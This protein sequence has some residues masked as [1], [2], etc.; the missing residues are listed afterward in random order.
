LGINNRIIGQSAA[1]RGSYSDRALQKR[2]GNLPRWKKEK[3]EAFVRFDND[4]KA[5]A[6][7]N[8][9]RLMELL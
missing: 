6:P 2:D 5:F 4:E 9:L 3:L 7:A 8:A 1:S